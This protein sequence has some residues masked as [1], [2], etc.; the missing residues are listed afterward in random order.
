MPF[1]MPLNLNLTL[2]YAS[3][4][5]SNFKESKHLQ[6]I[7]YT[8]TYIIIIQ[9]YE[10]FQVLRSFNLVIGTSGN[11][12]KGHEQVV[13]AAKMKKNKRKKQTQKE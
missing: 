1:F 12:K 2:E 10:T 3:C 11:Y 8:H 7:V 6:N 4:L 5:S 9:Q 13:V